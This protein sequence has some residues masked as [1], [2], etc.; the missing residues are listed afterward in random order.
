MQENELI[1]VTFGLVA[2]N[3][4]QIAD[5]FRI[6][7]CFGKSIRTKFYLI[8]FILIAFIVFASHTIFKLWYT[9]VSKLWLL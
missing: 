7:S 9:C 3:F 4:E 2:V 6:F 8:D 1:S 5:K